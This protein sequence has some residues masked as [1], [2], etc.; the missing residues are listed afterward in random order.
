M[1]L[2]GNDIRNYADTIVGGIGFYSPAHDCTLGIVL[3]YNGVRSFLTAS[4]CTVLTMVPDGDTATQPTHGPPF[5]VIGYESSDP[6]AFPCGGN[7]CRNADAAIYRMADTVQSQIGLIARTT[8]SA[9]SGPGS[10]T[11]DTSNPW[12]IINDLDPNP[13]VGTAINKM[14]QASGWTYGTVTGTCQDKQE[15][16]YPNQWV[17][18]NTQT[19]AYVHVGDSGGPVFEFDASSGFAKFAG[20]TWGEQT[21]FHYFSPL[22]QIDNDHTGTMSITRPY[23]LQSPVLTGSLSGSNPQIS[24]SAISGATKYLIYR[25]LDNSNCLT[26]PYAYRTTTTSTSYIDTQ[27]TS[28]GAGQA[29]CPYAKYYVI[30]ASQSDLSYQSSVACSSSLGEEDNSRDARD[31]A[32]SSASRTIGNARRSNLRFRSSGCPTTCGAQRRSGAWAAGCLGRGHRARRRLES[33]PTEGIE[34]RVCRAWQAHRRQCTSRDWRSGDRRFLS[35]ADG[36][37]LQPRLRRRAL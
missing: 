4:H 33:S 15:Q 19:D 25:A 3:N 23:A 24:W 21:G 35:S 10:M 16:F 6:W 13:V 7:L 9:H 27:T 26:S 17:Y 14:G 37:R 2:S 18:C 12:F 20:I 32:S 30:A 22:S 31:A 1:S 29:Q 8:S 34:C 5:H 28:I 36:L 11:W